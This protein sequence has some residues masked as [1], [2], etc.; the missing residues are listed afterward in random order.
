MLQCRVRLSERRLQRFYRCDVGDVGDET[1]HRTVIDVN[2]RRVRRHDVT[3]LAARSRERPLE[4][5]RFT[6]QRSQNVRQVRVLALIASL[7]TGSNGRRGAPGGG[8]RHN[9]ARCN[10][11]NDG[12]PTN[13]NGYDTMPNA[14]VRSTSAL[15]RE[16]RVSSSTPVHRGGTPHP[17]PQ[18]P[19]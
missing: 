15:G 8:N 17:P 10:R 12:Y 5:L 16:S 11:R 1:A 19:C 2:I 14:A 4:N 13:G 3:D 6:P 18:T 9:T 7:L